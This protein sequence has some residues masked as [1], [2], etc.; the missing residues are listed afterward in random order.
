MRAIISGYRAAA[1]QQTC[2]QICG[3]ALL[4]RIFLCPRLSFLI[5]RHLCLILARGTTVMRVEATELRREI[6]QADGAGLPL[7]KGSWR[8]WPVKEGATPP[9]T[10]HGPALR[11]EAVWS[12]VGSG[13]PRNYGC[14]VTTFSVLY[15]TT[16]IQSALLGITGFVNATEFKWSVLVTHL[17]SSTC[18]SANVSTPAPSWRSLGQSTHSG[19]PAEI[20]SHPSFILHGFSS[21]ITKSLAGI[22]IT[23]SLILS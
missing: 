8:D 15:W 11:T 14:P 5:A 6:R 7:A 19:M 2:G 16:Q 21:V 12:R 23:A 1:L 9:R 22:G 20:R 3:R 10:Q 4:G 18:P 13:Q 17:W